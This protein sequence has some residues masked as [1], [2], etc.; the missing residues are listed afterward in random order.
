M[1]ADGRKEATAE[2]YATGLSMNAVGRIVGASG[3]TVERWLRS[4][5][6][7]IRRRRMTYPD[8]IRAEAIKLYVEDELSA[9][10]VGKKL[11]LKA[12]TI[13]EWVKSA[14][15]V[16]SMSEAACISVSC[17]PRARATSR[18]W[19]RSLKTGEHHF[20]ESSLEYLRMQQLDDDPA[21]E[22]WGRCHERI[23]YIDPQ[24]GKRRNY[25]PDLTVRLSVGDVRIEELKP[26]S[27]LA[28][29]TNQAKFAA[30][31]SFCRDKGWSFLILTE[32]HVGYVRG[33][34]PSQLSKDEKL[35]RSNER[36]RARWAAETAEQRAE[37]LA[38]NAAYMRGY[39]KRRSESGTNI[40]TTVV[41]LYAPG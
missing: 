10:A 27:L 13:K 40:N 36:R 8:A 28:H 29:P 20:A 25:V 3:Q 21:I 9:A 33:L 34:E 38:K 41:T 23:P 1:I 7:E 6:V 2:L 4:S 19:Y 11:G 32:R 18:L 26:E 30:C 35:R 39:I 15:V 37:R 24:T 5:G 22:T 31:E 17:R 16:R 14:G 12:F